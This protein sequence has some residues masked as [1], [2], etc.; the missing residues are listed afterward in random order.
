MFEFITSSLFASFLSSDTLRWLCA[1]TIIMCASGRVRVQPTYIF[2]QPLVSCISLHIARLFRWLTPRFFSLRNA[3]T[4]LQL[5]FAAWH[6]SWLTRNISSSIQL[7]F[8]ISNCVK[9]ATLHPR[10]PLEMPF[11]VSFCCCWLWCNQE[12]ETRTSHSKKGRINSRNHNNYLSWLVT[13]QK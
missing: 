2:V 6:S 12:I 13:R 7:F 5:T 11:C 10:S 3:Y 8:H 1:A 4:I 9:K